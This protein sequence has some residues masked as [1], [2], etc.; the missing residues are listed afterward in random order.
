MNDPVLY[1]R[2]PNFDVSGAY[3]TSVGLLS[4][5][6]KGLPSH[7]PVKPALRT[8]RGATV[9]LRERWTLDV[10]ISSIDRKSIDMSSDASFRALNW[11]LE[12]VALVTGTDEDDARSERAKKLIARLFP[13]GLGFTQEPFSAQWAHAD[14]V[15][16]LIDEEVE[17][18]IAKLVGRHYGRCAVHRDGNRPRAT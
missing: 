4:A 1:S 7:S 6:P 2:A 11:S 13:L 5:A 3:S 15:V 18:D 12:A 16:N 10:T 8:L 14:R 17:A 9:S